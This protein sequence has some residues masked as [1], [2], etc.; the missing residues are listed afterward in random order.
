MDTGGGKALVKKFF[1]YLRW[2]ICVLA[3]VAV[4][5]FFVLFVVEP[6]RDGDFARFLLHLFF[7]GPFLSVLPLS[8]VFVLM[9]ETE[10]MKRERSEPHIGVCPD[11]GGAVEEY[12]GLIPPYGGLMGDGRG[13][14][15]THCHRTTKSL[16]WVPLETREKDM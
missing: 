13:W 8:I 4:L 9:P 14:I 12:D 10:K 1:Y 3:S 7:L 15:C 2:I 16:K 5:I 11:C 6:L